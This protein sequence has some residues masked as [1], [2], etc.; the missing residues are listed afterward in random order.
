MD[1]LHCG[2]SSYPPPHLKGKSA[3]STSTPRLLEPETATLSQTNRGQAVVSTHTARA[4]PLQLLSL[5][6]SLTQCCQFTQGAR[7]RNLS[8]THDRSSGL[9]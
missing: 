9:L 8:D 7:S 2:H 4:P 3:G 5:E 6:M 1:T